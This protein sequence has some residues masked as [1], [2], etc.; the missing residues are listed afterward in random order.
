MPDK[1]EQSLMTKIGLAVLGAALT[2][3]AA[4]MWQIDKDRHQQTELATQLAEVIKDLDKATDALQQV[5]LNTQAINQ[6]S[7]ASA[8]AAKWM[9][10]WPRTGLLQADVEQNANIAFLRRELDRSNGRISALER[11]LG[12][13]KIQIAT[14]GRPD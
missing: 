13:V 5:S 3:L 7:D 1:A 8:A 2:G 9:E 4:W 6:L 10:E 12:E 11:Q 14:N